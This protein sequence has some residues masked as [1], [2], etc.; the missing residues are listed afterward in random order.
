MSRIEIKPEKQEII[1]KTVQETIKRD[2]SKQETAIIQLVKLAKKELISKGNVKRIIKKITD[3]DYYL[4]IVEDIYHEISSIYDT[5]Y[6]LTENESNT[7]SESEVK[8]ILENIKSKKPILLRHEIS[9]DQ[10]V[11]INFKKKVV[12]REQTKIVNKKNFSKSYI[13]IEAVP[14]KVIVYDPILTDEPRSFE[15]YWKS[16]YTKKKFR[17]GGEIGGGGIIEIESQLEDSGYCPTPR[18]LKG[19]VSSVI[20][21]YIK[22]NLAIVKN[23][24]EYPGFFFDDNNQKIVNINYDLKTPSKEELLE[25]IEVIE[26]LKTF[27]NGNEDKLATCLKWGWLSPFSYVKKQVGE[28]IPYLY[29][30]GKGGTGKTAIA[31]VILYLWDKP[32]DGKNELSGSNFDTVPRIGSRISRWTLPL[33]VNEPG[34]ALTGVKTIDMIKS[35]AESTVAR[36]KYEGRRYKDFP[37]LSNSIFTSQRFLSTD[38][39]FLRRIIHLKF[40]LSDRKT[41]EEKQNFKETFNIKFPKKSILNK[42]KAIS[43]FFANEIQYNP[44][45]LEEDWQKIANEILFNMYVDVGLEMPKWLRNFVESSPLEEHDEEEKE[46]LRIFFIDEIN[47]NTKK[48]EVW[49]DDGFKKKGESLTSNGIKTNDD[50]HNRVWYVLNE[51]LIP[52]MIP[53]NIS[54]K[55]YV[56]LT[57]GLKKN[58]HKETDVCADLKSIAELLGWDY[59]G[60]RL[61]KGSNPQK[62]IKVSFEKFSNFLFPDAEKEDN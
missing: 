31:K 45:I 4:E 52:Y 26:L 46:D 23:K 13:V 25:A 42:L 3:N 17:T 34:G 35:A 8:T 44:K 19:I 43:Y 2:P 5:Y 27:Y 22:E 7:Y 53:V 50:F 37:A 38:D 12:E 18:L 33:I 61:S 54:G 21:C 24:V 30:E 9:D 41:D 48:V 59:T 39:G 58:L 60:V 29:L 6:D 51:R 16:N 32:I 28:Y 57:M 56:C 49:E 15:I 47:K 55:D 20:N 14:Q 10:A 11:I 1:I 62:V 40:F 36:G